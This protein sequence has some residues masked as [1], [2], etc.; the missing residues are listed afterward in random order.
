M[1][2]WLTA[3]RVPRYFPDGSV[4]K[5]PPANAGDRGSISDLGRSCMPQSNSACLLQLLSLCS[6]AGELQLLQLAH[7]EPEPTN[8]KEEQPLLDTTRERPTKQQRSST[9]KNKSNYFL[10]ERP[11]VWSFWVILSFFFNSVEY[12][13]LK[14]WIWRTFSGNQEMRTVLILVGRLHL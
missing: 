7:L 5:N 4:V 10:K 14:S 1:S 13:L 12:V 11:T 2:A 9:V 3:S 6:R 8:C